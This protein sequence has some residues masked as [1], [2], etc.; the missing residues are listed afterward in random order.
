MSK[1]Q[2]ATHTRGPWEYHAR[3][4]ASENHKGY[5]VWLTQPDG[6]GLF[7][8]EVSPIDADGVTGE[9]NARLIAAAP[10]LLE[11]LDA[12]ASACNANH[13]G[14]DDSFCS[15]CTATVKAEQV[16]AKARGEVAS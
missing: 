5:N 1:Q 3:L 2:V 13:D 11:A 8:A 10:E 16:I 4:S 15:V 12:L 7:V 14:H 9:H 6:H